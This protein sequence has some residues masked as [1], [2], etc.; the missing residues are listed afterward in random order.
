MSLVE[1]IL[2]T[3]FNGK[4]RG[5]KREFSRAPRFDASAGHSKS[6]IN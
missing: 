3:V 4:T 5:K 1:G 6:E 2:Y